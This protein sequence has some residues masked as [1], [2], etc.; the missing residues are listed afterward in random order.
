M[1]GESTRNPALTRLSSALSLALALSSP[2]AHALSISEIT[3]T[4]ALNSP[5]KGVLN[6]ELE[7][8]ETLGED[9]LKVQLASPKAHAKAGLPY[10]AM[11]KNLQ[12]VQ[13]DSIGRDIRFRLSTDRP[14]REPIISLILEAEWDSGNLKKEITLLL[15]P[16]DY[17]AQLAQAS[18]AFSSAEENELVAEEV[19]SSRPSGYANNRSERSDPPIFVSTPPAT[20]V[21]GSE[22]RPVP[23]KPRPRHRIT[24]ENGEYGPVKRGDSLSKIAI[25]AARQTGFTAE[26]MMNLIYEANPTAFGGSKDYLIEGSTLYIPGL[27]PALPQEYSKKSIVTAPLPAQAAPSSSQP[28]LTIVGP[29]GEEAASGASSGSLDKGTASSKMTQAPDGQASTDSDAAGTPQEEELELQVQ[30]LKNENAELQNKLSNT[31]EE[32]GTMKNEL[33]RLVVELR[34]LS[35][36][37]K[38]QESEKPASLSEQIERWLP[39]LLLF[40]TLPAALLLGTRNRKQELVIGSSEPAPLPAS[41]EANLPPQPSMRPPQVTPPAAQPPQ[42]SPPAETHRS[43][44]AGL[45]QDPKPASALKSRV[46]SNPE[47]TSSNPIPEAVFD[48][49]EDDL[50]TLPD[51]NE[52]AATTSQPDDTA[53]AD[54]APASFSLLDEAEDL[55]EKEVAREAEPLNNSPIAGEPEAVKEEPSQ[56]EDTVSKAANKPAYQD[57]TQEVI[58]STLGKLGETQ[59]IN[60][61]EMPRESDSSS[62][63]ATQEAE[64]YIAYDQFSLAEKTINRLLKASP[65]NDRYLLLQLKLFAE[66][67][68]LDELQNLSIKLLH[69]HP[70]P[71]SDFNQRIRSI[72]DRAFT[73]VDIK[74]PKITP[75]STRGSDRVHAEN[76]DN[77]TVLDEMTAETLFV[78]GIDDYIDD[79]LTEDDELVHEE[80]PDASLAGLEDDFE[81]SDKGSLGSLTTELPDHLLKDIA[82]QESTDQK[83][84][85]SATDSELLDPDDI[86]STLSDGLDIP[87]DLEWEIKKYESELEQDLD[88][89]KDEDK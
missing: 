41:P 28:R 89:S 27:E 8:G 36:I 14:V 73:Q 53:E 71:D 64:I 39:W 38:L 43:S 83:D 72:C 49:P 5:L 25:V 37:R 75:R 61:G 9:E 78:D 60:P 69:K 68:R 65:D 82:R 40:I 44:Q 2:L 33:D 26:T 63:D 84:K 55:E 48:F 6:V 56:A 4:S 13:E 23:A 86:E 30:I 7:P 11:L 85:N 70:D 34:S 31:T 45:D 1:T 77:E 42:S 12:V 24:I 46:D 15:D 18:E 81:S 32:L 67:G 17:T 10:P 76:I 52:D 22:A 87:F 58:R 79:T 80:D 54:I 19:Q 74:Q 21:S 29:E 35:E 16:A 66:T 51:D 47:A 62:L 59:L 57:D 3:I 20:P 88:Q 50:E